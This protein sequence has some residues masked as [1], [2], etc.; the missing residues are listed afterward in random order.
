LI[1]VNG[2]LLGTTLGGDMLGAG[3]RRPA[4]IAGEPEEIFRYQ[5]YRAPRT[6]LPRRVSRRIDDNLTHD[7]PTG[8]V[9]IAARNQETGQ[10]LGY[11]DSS[12]L[13]PVTVQ[14]PQCGTHVPAAL[15]CPGEL[16]RTPPRL[17]SFIIDPSTVLDRNAAHPHARLLRSPSMRPKVGH[18]VKSAAGADADTAAHRGPE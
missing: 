10:R 8:M 17:A 2:D 5:G 18:R 14:V 3:Q 7:S 15:H 4:T 9:R 11:T 16:P 6:P 13:G 12:G 1:N